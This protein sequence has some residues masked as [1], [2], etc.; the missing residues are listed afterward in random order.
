M[1]THVS[2]TD[3]RRGASYWRV[4]ADLNPAIPDPEETAAFA[5]RIRAAAPALAAGAEA[6][7]D[8]YFHVPALGRHR[9]VYHFYLEGYATDDPAADEA[10]ARRAGAATIDAYAAALGA[11]LERSGPPTDAERRAQLDYHTLYLF[12]VLTLDRGTTSG[13]LVHD[14]NDVGIMGSLPSRVDPARLAAWR[15]RMP[16]PQERLLDALVAALP[17]ASPARVDAATRRALAAAVRAHYR[18]HPEA[19]SLQ[20]SGDAVPPTVANHR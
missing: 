1:H 17:D 9:G 18:A 3:L 11:A 8:R 19:L 20:A 2:W 15:D 7:G 16:A 4:M 14:Q 13:L 10:L 12:Q 5:A 6:R